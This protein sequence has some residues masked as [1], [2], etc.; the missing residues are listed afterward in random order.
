M[1]LIHIVNEKVKDGDWA[2][3]CDDKT[4][5]KRMADYID[6]HGALL[7]KNSNPE[8]SKRQYNKPQSSAASS[9]KE[10]M[11]ADKPLPKAKARAKS[12]ASSS[13]AG[14]QVDEEHKK[15]ATD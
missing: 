6:N 15:R 13:K 11:Q 7:I 2:D 4:K 14:M 3:Q 12:V 9:S 1:Q 10:G 5:W 8:S